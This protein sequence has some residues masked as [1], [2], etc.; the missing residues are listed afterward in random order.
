MKL[1]KGTFK[2][3]ES[4]LYYYHDTKREIEEIRNDIIH[5]SSPYYD[6]LSGRSNTKSDPTGRLATVLTTDRKLKQLERI[7]TSIEQ[8]YN[9]LPPEKQKLI[10]LKYWTKPQLLT[11]EGIAQ[12]LNISRRQAFRWRDEIVCSIADLIGL[13]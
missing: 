2:H 12:Q 9:D 6:D 5:S 10:D 13:R 1:R 8:V 3:I 7:V 11:W 4:E